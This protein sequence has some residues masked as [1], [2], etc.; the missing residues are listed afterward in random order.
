MLFLLII[1]GSAIL[2]SA[3]TVHVRK[4]AFE[5]KFASIIAKRKAASQRRRTPSASGF[6]LRTVM[7]FAKD[8][9]PAPEDNPESA[10]AEKAPSRQSR[11]RS[12]SRGRN[13]S[14]R[15]VTSSDN[16][17]VVARESDSDVELDESNQP[18]PD[19][20]TF[21]A[22]TR[23]RSP[24]SPD[25]RQRHNSI[26]SAHGVGARSLSGPHSS[27]TLQ[28][29][30]YKPDH[31]D[32]DPFNRA[33][34]LTN[35]YFPSSG[36]ISRNSRFYGL[37]EAEREE[38]GGV[39]YKAVCFLSWLVPLYFVLFQLLGCIGLA[40]YVAIN[41]PAAAQAN[42]L[43]PWWVGAFNGVSA[44]NNSGMSLL[45]ANMTAFQ[46]SYY[47]CL[48]MGLMILAGNTC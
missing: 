16:P 46:T 21:S 5:K 24:K 7:S 40:A 22:G 37:S 14:T 26:F 35:K 11:D 8:P 48:T 18:H 39:E 42:A 43:N 25:L 30:T 33:T 10:P 47:M 27:A 23:F 6:S 4:R 29:A 17:P 19:R 13:Q 2:V 44:F 12:M 1:L 15:T 36:Y 31:I 3:V 9:H 45:D 20:V 32:G 41:R 38:L 28:T 34:G